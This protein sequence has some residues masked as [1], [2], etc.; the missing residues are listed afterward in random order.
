[1][2]VSTRGKADIVFCIDGSAS[3]GPCFGAV[4]Q[5]LGLFLEAL[6]GPNLAGWDVRLDYV[7]HSVGA[8][9]KGGS[10]TRIE[11]IQCSGG[12]LIAAVANMDQNRLFTRDVSAFKQSLAKVEVQGDEDSLEGLDLALDFPWRP[13]SEAHR[14]VIFLTDESL[15]DSLHPKEQLA[16][17]S[18]VS[19]KIQALGVLLFIVAP[20][21]DGYYQLSETDKAMFQPAGAD[22]DG[23]RSIDFSKLFG[24]IGKS[25]SVAALQQGGREPSVKRDLFG[26]R[27]YGN[28]GNVRL[29]GR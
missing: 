10:V 27:A 4:T 11:S 7:V 1:M 3:M 18:E 2:A 19:N 22:N 15:E 17:I 8:T 29:E 16:A 6:N 28:A 23:L 12:D 20:A 13:R 14:V 21:S 26:M 5:S 24:T 9:S 25:L